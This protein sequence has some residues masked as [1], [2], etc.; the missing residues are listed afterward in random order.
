MANALVVF[1][2]PRHAAHRRVVNLKDSMNNFDITWKHI[3]QYLVQDIDDATLALCVQWVKRHD[4][5]NSTALAAPSQRM[6]ATS[7]KKDGGQRELA[8]SI[9]RRSKWFQ[10]SLSALDWYKHERG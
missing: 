10:G 9:L 2:A 4:L 8:R 1:S 6:H 7:L 5:F 3:F